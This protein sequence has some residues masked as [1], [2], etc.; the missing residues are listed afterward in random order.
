MTPLSNTQNWVGKT[1]LLLLLITIII[2]F[3][4]LTFAFT[5]TARPQV[6]LTVPSIF[7]LNTFCLLLSSWLFHRAMSMEIGSKKRNWQMGGIWTGILFLVAQVYAWIE[8]LN[9][10]LG[11]SGNGPELSFLYLL[12]GLHALHL[13]G[14]L[15]FMGIIYQ[16]GQ[17]QDYPYEE[18]GIYFWHFL[19][20]LWLFLLAVLTLQS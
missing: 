13:V 3:G 6:A 2:L 1:G 4:T 15:I 9:A 14:G 16:K 8:M 5:L 19:G 11:I 10:G 20:V 12:S 18:V 7:Y 17:E